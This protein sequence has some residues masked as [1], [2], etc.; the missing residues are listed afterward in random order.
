MSFN[1][2]VGGT[3]QTLSSAWVKVAGTWQEVSSAWVKVAG[4]WEEVF[5]NLAVTLYPDTFTLHTTGDNDPTYSGIQLNSNGTQYRYAFNGGTLGLTTWLLGGTAA[6]FWARCTVNAGTL[7]GGSS[8]TGTWL[9]LAITRDWYITDSIP[10][11]GTVTVDFDIE[12]ATDASGVD[13]IK[14]QNYTPETTY[15]TL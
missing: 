14:S 13:I 12:I 6:Q 5:R 15:N 2:K 7:D 8:A 3:W 9:N 4:T 11:S 1:F 10:N